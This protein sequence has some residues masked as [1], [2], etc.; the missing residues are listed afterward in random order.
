M[1]PLMA[2]VGSQ[3]TDSQRSPEGTGGS[4]RYAATVPSMQI[5]EM[6]GLKL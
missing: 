4:A 2:L 3:V 6:Q 5:R 1:Q